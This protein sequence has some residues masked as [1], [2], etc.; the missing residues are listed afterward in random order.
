M[1]SEEQDL[2]RRKQ[3]Q[4]MDECVQDA[5]YIA[6]KHGINQ[7]DVVATLAAALFRERI[8]E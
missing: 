7:E 1:V 4:L 6:I 3:I 8:K 5:K 2:I